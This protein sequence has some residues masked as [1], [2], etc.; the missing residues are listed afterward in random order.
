GLDNKLATLI[1]EQA[2][3][4]DAKLSAML[5]TLTCIAKEVAF[6][7]K[8]TRKIWIFLTVKLPSS[9]YN[10]SDQDQA[11]KRHRQSTRQSATS[12]QPTGSIPT[13]TGYQ[14]TRTW[15]AMRQ[16]TNWRKW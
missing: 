6:T 13:S 12:T 8:Q 3:V 16:Q 5:I 15:T 11:N 1:S 2:E 10:T 7:T 9:D 4:F 14:D